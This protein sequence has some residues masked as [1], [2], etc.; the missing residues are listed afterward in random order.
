MKGPP[1]GVPET[2]NRFKERCFSLSFDTTFQ[3]MDFVASNSTEAKRCC[4]M[5]RLIIAWYQSE[6][7]NLYYKLLGKLSSDE[8]VLLFSSL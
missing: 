4:D 6:G 2:D 5:Y 3:Y 8:Q 7:K 1:P